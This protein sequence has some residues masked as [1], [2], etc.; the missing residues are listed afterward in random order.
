MFKTRRSYADNSASN[1]TLTFEAGDILCAL[2]KTNDT[3]WLA[4][5]QH[6]SVGYVLS[7]Y[8]E[9]L[10]F[11]QASY[12]HRH[13]GIVLDGVKLLVNICFPDYS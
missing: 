9:P 4:L 10:E 13:T 12:I 7:S 6:G 3:W 8:L 5:N 2:E 1:Y 11:E